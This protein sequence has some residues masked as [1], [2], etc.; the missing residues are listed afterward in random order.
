MLSIVNQLPNYN[1]VLTGNKVCNMRLSLPS[2]KAVHKVFQ[3]IRALR[4]GH[5]AGDNGKGANG[6]KVGGEAIDRLFRKGF[7]PG[8]NRLL[9]VRGKV[10]RD[11]E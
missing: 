7:E 5:D 9:L 8:K 11:L 10:H 3:L 1:V 6:P 2:L 4:P